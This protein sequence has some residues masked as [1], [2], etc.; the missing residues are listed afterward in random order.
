MKR[1]KKLFLLLE[2][3]LVMSLFTG[4]WNYTEIEKDTIVAGVAIDKG[5]NGFKYHVTYEVLSLSGGKDQS[6]NS[7]L[8]QSDGDTVFDAIRKTV[9]MADKKLYFSDCKI[10]IVSKEIAKEGIEPLLDFFLRDQ[11]PR[12]TLSFAV[13][14]EDTAAKILDIQLKTKEAVSYKINGMLEESERVSGHILSIPLYQMYNILSSKSEDLTLPDI[15]VADVEGDQEPQLA[16]NVI[17]RQDKMVGYMPE[18]ECLYYLMLKNKI[19]SGILVT[20]VKPGD[21]DISLEIFKC[22]TKMQPVVSGTNVIM[23]IQIQVA[24][25]IAEENN[26]K[27]VYTVGNG[28]FRMLEEAASRTVKEGAEKLILD[29]QKN[30]GADIF[31]FGAKIDQDDY[32]DWEKIQ[33]NWDNI[34][35]NV[36]CDVTAD[37][38]ILNSATALP[39]GG[40]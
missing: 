11:E 35:P 14:D 26:S 24:A 32:D 13:S 34:F 21:K 18:D 19:H 22:S 2:T 12:I 16:T 9:A 40:G 17:F 27:E 7:V 33:S 31:G 3:V 20:S 4:C 6:I 25:D 29:T 8:L 15:R 28:E 36:K 38:K 1:W 37:V 30:Y 23:K 10:I 39:K 5:T